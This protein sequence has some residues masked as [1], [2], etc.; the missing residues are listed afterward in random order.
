MKFLLLLSATA[1]AQLPNHLVEY[2]IP[3]TAQKCKISNGGRT[4]THGNSLR[5]ECDGTEVRVKFGISE[6][7]LYQSR[8]DAEAALK[9]AGLNWTG[10]E[11]KRFEVK[12]DDQIKDVYNYTFVYEK[13]R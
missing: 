6:Q 5:V 11:S 4:G 7:E 3:S 13:G 2:P 9:A 10:T 8:L 12:R 1:F